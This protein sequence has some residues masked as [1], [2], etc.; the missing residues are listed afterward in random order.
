MN[1]VARVE[2]HAHV[3]R[4]ISSS[5]AIRV[6]FPRNCVNI[7]RNERAMNIHEAYFLTISLALSCSFSFER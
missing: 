7:I 6:K 1:V 4:Y 3:M 2:L 5:P